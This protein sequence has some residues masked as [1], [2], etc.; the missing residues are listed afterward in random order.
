MDSEKVVK[1]A[2]CSQDAV[3]VKVVGDHTQDARRLCWSVPALPTEF[4]QQQQ[5][6]QQPQ[7]Q[8]QQQQSHLQAVRG[9]P[10]LRKLKE[11]KEE[12]E[13]NSTEIMNNQSIEKSVTSAKL[14]AETVEQIKK[15]P[16]RTKKNSITESETEN[17]NMEVNQSKN[18]RCQPPILGSP[19][20]KSRR[21]AA[22]TTPSRIMSPRSCNLAKE[23]TRCETKEGN[24]LIE[25]LNKTEK[26]S[27]RTKTN[28]ATEDK[29]KTEKVNSR[30]RN[31]SVTENLSKS[32]KIMEMEPFEKDS[33]QPPILGSPEPKSR[34]CI[35]PTTPLR[36]MSPRSCNLAKEKITGDKETK[37]GKTVT[38]NLNTAGK[39]NSRTRKNLVTDNQNRAGKAT[40][41][42]RDNSVTEK[43]TKT[44]KIVDVEHPKNELSQPPI[45]CSPEPR[46]RGCT[47]Q[48]TPSRFLSPRSCNLSKEKAAGEAKED[49]ALDECKKVGRSSRSLKQTMD[50]LKDNE[51]VGQEEMLGDENKKGEHRHKC[52]TDNSSKNKNKTGKGDLKQKLVDTGKTDSK[53]AAEEC[54][55]LRKVK[56][57]QQRKGEKQPLQEG[58]MEED[59]PLIDILENKRYEEEPLIKIQ[60]TK[61]E[62]EIP[63]IDI[64]EKKKKEEPLVGITECGMNNSMDTPL[65]D[66]QES[67]REEEPL[68]KIQESKREEEPLIK[69]QESKR[70]EEELLIKIQGKEKKK[71]K[72]KASGDLTASKPTES[73]RE[74]EPEKNMV[75]E[76]DVGSKKPKET[77]VIKET[78]KE[79]ETQGKNSSSNKIE[80]TK[81][82]KKKSSRS[83]SEAAAADLKSP[84]RSRSRSITETAADGKPVADIVL[85]PRSPGGSRSKLEISIPLRQ[86]PR[87]L[88]KPSVLNEGEGDKSGKEA[89]TG[90]KRSKAA[91]KLVVQ[92]K[93]TKKEIKEK[94]NE[95]GK[96]KQS[97][98]RS[99]TKEGTCEETDKEK[100]D[101]PIEV[102]LL[103]KSLAPD[104][105]IF[106]SPAVTSKES[107]YTSRVFN[108]LKRSIQHV[109]EGSSSIC[110]VSTEPYAMSGYGFSDL[111][112]VP[113]IYFLKTKIYKI[114]Q[115]CC[116]GLHKT[117]FFNRQLMLTSTRTC[118]HT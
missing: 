62:E 106:E 83:I 46:S 96:S 108:Q 112:H 64:Q 33:S 50:K 54:E 72:K 91:K 98:I 70:E 2:S 53:S 100:T 11:R 65:I 12:D 35:A 67:K 8:Q 93:E 89:L 10:R 80:V 73:I 63:L 71:Q 86:S 76:V 42:T 61:R 102:K 117:F 75:D 1:S 79:S 36:I 45:L 59:T 44:E 41:R 115:L 57:D 22:Q 84:R 21:P 87:I 13:E 16:S 58:K 101:V 107:P 69:I 92:A 20:P 38:E 56:D 116:K 105:N 29:T 25:T 66:I 118:S 52:N 90:S 47:S 49:T 3:A 48:R 85:S 99:T 30:R 39:M 94:E 77:K 103:T 60:E 68:I 28:S 14:E 40:S 110:D 43:P 15:K 6:Q 74:N 55:A 97:V 26:M 34:R 24:S 37:K 78:Q 82:E 109:E 95:T 51:K 32:E 7:Q 5:Q 17:V 31:N 19:E 111:S 4:E 104:V 27:T 114:G 81:K 23:K 113:G 9:S 18:E 88:K